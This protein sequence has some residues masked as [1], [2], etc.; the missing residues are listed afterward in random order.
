[1]Q[2]FLAWMDSTLI[3]A[4]LE[5]GYRVEFRLVDKENSQFV[6]CVSLEG[7]EA[8]FLEIQ[9]KYNDSPQRA[10][11]FESSPNCFKSLSVSFVD[12]LD[13]PK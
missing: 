12:A 4:R 2:D 13:L 1:M 11:A 9:A 8:D 7:T 5:F 3:P 10:K 6:W